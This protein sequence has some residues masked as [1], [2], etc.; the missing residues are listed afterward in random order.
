MAQ[1]AYC[2]GCARRVQLTESGE[3]PNGHLRSMLRDVRKD[4][5]V[6]AEKPVSGPMARTSPAPESRDSHELLSVIIGKA[7]VLVPVAALGA[8]ALWTGYEQGVGSGLSAG[9]AL[10]VSLGSLALTIGVVFAWASM[11]RRK[12]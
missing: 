2:N 5:I 6:P 4:E 11:R 3:C 8:F 7:L 1:G 9:V 12:N 10:L